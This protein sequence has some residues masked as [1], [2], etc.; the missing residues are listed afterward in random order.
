MVHRDARRLALQALLVALVCC[1]NAPGQGLRSPSL[2]S[3]PATEAACGYAAQVAATAVFLSGRSLDSVRAEELAPV[4]PLQALVA[5]GLHLEADAT[6]RCITARIGASSAVAAFVEG[7]GCTLVHQADGESLDAAL[8]RVRVRALALP[9]RDESVAWPSGEGIHVDESAPVARE[10]ALRAALD[11]A[12]EPPGQRG[13]PTTRAIVVVHEGRIVAERHAEGL[14]PHSPLP[15]WS[16]TKTWVDALLGIRMRQGRLDPDALLPV[17]AWANPRADGTEDPRRALRVD[18]LLRMESGLRWEEDYSNPASQAAQMLF[19]A[20]DAAAVAA[21]LEPAHPPGVQWNYSSASTNL[22]CG[23]LRTT[24]TDDAEHARFAREQLFGPLGMSTASLATDDTGTF[25]G[26]SFGSASARDWARFGLFYLQDGTWDGKQVLPEGWV[27]ASR[28]PA[29]SAPRGGYGRH[30]WLNA[31][32]EG[33]PD[34]RRYR[35]LPADMFHLSGF[36]GQ[37][38]LCFPTER[39]VLVRM[40][41]DVA[42]SFDIERLAVTVLRALGRGPR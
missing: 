34:D 41:T 15:G 33:S 27:A 13:G 26:S 22:L 42:G 6:R 32:S 28:T 14:G 25:V 39:V 36:Q 17:A 30:L 4:T 21:A 35:K 20:N 19:R 11:R 3:L 29:K 12:F 18:H 23:I 24:F 31:G 37:Y 7:M 5:A 2:P 38:V 9:A 1:T 8:A 10:R 40:G 16:M